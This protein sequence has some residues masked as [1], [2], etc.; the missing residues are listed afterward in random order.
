MATVT[1]LRERSDGRV[2][3]PAC[4]ERGGAAL[5]EPHVV[6]EAIALEHGQRLSPRRRRDVGTREPVVELAA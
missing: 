6:D 3:V 1:A 4:G 2:A 5:G